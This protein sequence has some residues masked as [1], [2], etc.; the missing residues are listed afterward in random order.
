MKFRVIFLSLLGF[1]PVSA[2]S[3][4]TFTVSIEAPGYSE[5]DVRK[6]IDI[7]RSKCQPLGGEVWSDLTEVKAE[8]EVETARHR[9][10]RGWTNTLHLALRYSETPLVGPVFDEEAGVLTGHVLHYDIGGGQSPGFLA[11]KRSSQ[12]LCGLPIEGGRDVFVSVPEFSFLDR[13]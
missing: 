11:G 10:D 12:F 13:K 8:I 7:F 4:D 6:A 3:A 1:L 9:L 5:Q 2:A